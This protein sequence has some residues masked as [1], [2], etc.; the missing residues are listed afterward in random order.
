MEENGRKSPSERINEML[1][2][3]IGSH[4]A[5]SKAD[6]ATLLDITPETLSRFYPARGSRQ[7]P[8]GK[9]STKNSGMRSMKIGWS[10]VKENPCQEI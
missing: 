6:F 9:H 1:K 3:A 5:E 8:R 10:R 2:F 7:Q 4:L